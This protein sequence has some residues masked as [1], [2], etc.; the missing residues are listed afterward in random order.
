MQFVGEAIALGTV[1]CWTFS[2]QFFA[3]A[4]REVGAIPV[5]IIRLSVALLL[6][7]VLLFFRDGTL[8]PVDFPVRSW[9]FLSLS[10]VIGFFIGDI[11]LFKALV[12]VG[13]TDH[14]VDSESGCA[15]SCGIRLDF[16][17]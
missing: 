13:A 1:M 8:L 17:P 15:Y 5:N 11:F 2:V 12:L 10:G 14:H 4:S 3:A 16:S 7:G 6:F 9:L